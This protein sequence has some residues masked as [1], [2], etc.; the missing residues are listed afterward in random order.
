MKTMNRRSAIALGVTATAVTPLFTL[1]ASAKT[2]E[3][4]PT[5]GKEIAPG[6]RLVEVGT[7]TSDIPAY[8]SISIV[9]FVFQPGAV[10]PEEV[11]D[12]DMVCTIAAGE[13]TIKKAD[14]EFKLREG[15]MYTCAKGK[16]DGAT[17][18]S[19]VV[20]VHRIAILIPA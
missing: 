11:M 12:N 1:A 16:T 20:G 7:G 10:A 6:V 14:K 4:G 15:D 2:K 13:F 18:T 17:N 9:D 19:A 8:K 3:Y 5:E